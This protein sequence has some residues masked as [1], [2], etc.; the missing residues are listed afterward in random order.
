MVLNIIALL[1]V[2]AITFLHSLFGLFS[3]L[4]NVFCSI[5]ALAI[6]F[7]CTE[8]VNR[9]VTGAVPVPS[10]YTEACV[11][12][13]LFVVSL[14]I[15]RVLADTFI[16]GNV[17]VPMYLDWGGGAVCGFI[18][19]Q[20]C[21]G[22]LILGF[23]ML[24]WGGRV[25][26]FSRMERDPDNEVDSET[27]RAVFRTNHIW[28][29]SDRF[30]VGLFNLLSNG[31]L[32]G[33]TSFASVYP[34]FPS[35]VFWTG[36]QIQPEVPPSVP[37]DDK[38]DGFDTKG[39]QVETWWTQTAPLA[40]DYTR[41]RKGYP[42]KGNDKPP[43]EPYQLRPQPGRTLLGV[44]LKLLDG[45]A[46]RDKNSI[47]HRFR[48]SNIRLVGDIIQRRPPPPDRL[49]A[50]GHRWCGREPRRSAARG[51][52]RQQLLDRRPRGHQDRRVFRSRRELQAALRGIP[53]HARAPLT[54]KPAAAPPPQRLAAGE[55][56]KE[57][58]GPRG[59]GP[60][61]FIDVVVRSASG[62]ND[63]L[64]VA[65]LRERVAAEAELSGDLFV[66]GSFSGDVGTLS[67]GMGA[68][69]ERFAV[70]EGKR[71]FQLQTMPRRAQS[72]FG[73]I[74]N[75]VGART[76]QYFAVDREGT[77][78]GLAGYYAIVKREGKEFLELFFTPDPEGTGFRGMVD[79]K[80]IRFNEL[81][82]EDSVLG[83]IFLV[84]PG[85]CIVA[86]RSQGGRVD[87][88]AEMCVEP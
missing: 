46:D 16:R 62:A 24:P 83:L 18:N 76:N 37:R 14:L 59:R 84:P 13:L 73:Q 43:Y 87:L 82:R 20:I 48:P 52:H 12:V 60:A 58:G 63:R 25:L 57:A 27:G 61:R 23:L 11:F 22:V 21:V 49:S 72:L 53:R 39:L 56:E 19:A 3:G 74:F 55:G 33:N 4:L 34:D 64:P 88:G 78:Y 67:Q 66:S 85:K 75:F 70:P 69:V 17:R 68:R 80:E 32:R 47:V 35:W 40:N 28:L 41:Y 54:G 15:L 9:L 79:L 7:G 81:D 10:A 6:A 29:R 51:R 1:L 86:V 44:R 5:S 42:T 45:S 8:A 71:I 26:G 38:V 36:N 77:E 50:A 65:V 30:A 2:L 31:S